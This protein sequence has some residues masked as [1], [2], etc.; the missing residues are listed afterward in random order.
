LTFYEADDPTC[1]P[2]VVN[3]GEGYVDN[4]HGHLGRNES[5]APA[6]DVSVILAPVGLPFRGELPAPNPYCEF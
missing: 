1:T 3:E 5:G 4:G 6:I 2:K